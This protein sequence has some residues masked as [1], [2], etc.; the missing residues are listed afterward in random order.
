MKLKM[1][2]SIFVLFFVFNA[3]S[4]LNEKMEAICILKDEIKALV[5][6][7]IIP[8]LF[9]EESQA[10]ISKVA[11]ETQYWDSFPKANWDDLD[12]DN[13]AISYYLLGL[14]KNPLFRGRNEKL[15]NNLPQKL[16]D[17][18]EKVVIHVTIDRY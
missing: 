5:K 15:F 18:I 9:S 13:L 17:L 16:R 12:D 3:K 6:G 4:A 1:I 7:G 8:S 2:C 14:N 11:S 10:K